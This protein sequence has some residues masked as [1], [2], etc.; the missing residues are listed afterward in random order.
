MIRLLI[1]LILIPITLYAGEPPDDPRCCVTEIK[2][3]PNGK[4]ARDRAVVRQFKERWPCPLSAE[5]CKDYHVDH[6]VP[7][8][9]G[10]VDAIYNLQWLKTDIKN[11]AG[12]D[13]KDRWERDFYC[14]KGK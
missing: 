9:C 11:C 12:D 6:V 1:I 5:A 4:I 13:C 3:A 2:R 8:A 14:N 10:G 7:L